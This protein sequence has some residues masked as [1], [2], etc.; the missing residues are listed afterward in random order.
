VTVAAF[1]TALNEIGRQGIRGPLV[2]AGLVV[3][4]IAGAFLVLRE[5]YGSNPPLPRVMLGSRPLTG[6]TVIGYLFNFGFYGMIFAASVYF[7]QHEK[8]SAAYT[9]LALLPAVAVT[10]VASALSGRLA[11]RFAHRRLMIIGL[12]TACVGLAIWA[13]AGDSP[14]YAILVI[15]M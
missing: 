6:G 12:L 13:V 1:I 8:L 15:A 9:G 7:Q 4:V 3:T 2:I 10:M 14:S 5:R 11:G